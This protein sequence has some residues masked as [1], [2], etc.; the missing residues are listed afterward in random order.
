MLKHKKW[1]FAYIH[2]YEIGG[3]ERW[4]WNLGNVTLLLLKQEL[5]S[6]ET[7]SDYTEILILLLYRR[8]LKLPVEKFKIGSAELE[9][10]IQ[11]LTWN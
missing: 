7:W 8:N 4:N 3:A 5:G 9:I 10:E 11:L 2:W 1:Q 6:L